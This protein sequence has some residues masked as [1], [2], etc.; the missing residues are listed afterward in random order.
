[1]FSQSEARKAVKD[2][3]ERGFRAGYLYA[4]QRNSDLTADVLKKLEY[5]EDLLLDIVERLY[6]AVRRESIR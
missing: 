3:A 4:S 5:D 6:E 2:L 1:M